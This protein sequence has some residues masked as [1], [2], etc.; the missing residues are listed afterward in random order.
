V[1]IAFEAMKEETGKD[2][3]VYAV[4]ARSYNDSEL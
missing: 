1:K 4:D 2:L 3:Y